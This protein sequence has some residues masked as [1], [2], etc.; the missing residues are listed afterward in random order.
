MLLPRRFFLRN[1]A[2]SLLAVK[3][4][5]IAFAQNHLN[6]QGSDFDPE[7]LAIFD[8]ISHQTFEPWIGSRFR[9]SLNNKSLG[10]AGSSIR[11]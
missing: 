6:G 1:A 5:L 2:L 3:L 8:G 9:L 7:S 10:L 11:Q 4:P